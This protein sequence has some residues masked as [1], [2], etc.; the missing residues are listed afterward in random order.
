MLNFFDVSKWN[1]ESVEETQMW[2]LDI[3]KY[4]G[5]QDNFMQN[6]Y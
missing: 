1:S 6:F 3:V 4:L 5:K 2:L